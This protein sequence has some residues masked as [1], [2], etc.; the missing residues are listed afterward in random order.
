[1]IRRAL[2]WLFIDR[3]T[4]RY[5]IAQFPNLS[6]S[7]WLAATMVRL[8]FTPDGTAGT[9]VRGIGTAALLWW[10]ADELLRGV[11]PWRRMLGATV[12]TFTLIGLVAG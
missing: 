3:R 1:M 12:G 9:V 5:T 8:V 11:N 4:G 2:D 10:A 6:I 7:I